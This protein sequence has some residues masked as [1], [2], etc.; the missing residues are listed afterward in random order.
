MSAGKDRVSEIVDYAIL[1]GDDSACKTFNVSRTT[2]D[3]YRRIYKEH[4]GENAD[5]LLKIKSRYSEDELRALSEGTRPKISKNVEYDF[6]GDELSFL[7]M[8]DT[9]I[10]SLYSNEA[11]LYAAFDEGEK[12]KVNALIHVGDVT[13]GM[14]GRPNSVL[15]LSHIGYKAQ[16]SEAIRLFSNWKKKA[17]F[18][19]G[20]HDDFFNT[21][22]GV[23]IS[24]VEDI[25][26]ELPDAEFVGEISGDIILKPWNIKINLFHGNDA[27][28]SYAINQV[29]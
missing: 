10:G 6:V 3:R 9:H 20:N 17:Y 27:G 24:M 5:L 7:V 25:C 21:K 16:K 14:S 18:I 19:S 22:L 23:G 11:R 4:F 1:H 28:S 29:S 12:Q 2:L 15:E 26:K 13:D 8:T